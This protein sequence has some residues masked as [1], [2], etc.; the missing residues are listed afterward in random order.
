MRTARR[1]L[2]RAPKPMDAASP[3][4][5]LSEAGRDISH[6]AGRRRAGAL[7][8]LKP[9][10]HAIERTD[11][12]PALTRF[13][14][15]APDVELVWLSDGVA[16][17][18]CRRIR[19]AALRKY[20]RQ[21][22]R[23]RDRR[24]RRAG[25]CAEC[26]RQCS[27]RADRESTTRECAD[28]EQAAWCARSISKV[29]P[30]GEARF[31][32]KRQ[33]ARNRSRRSTFRSR[34]ATISL[35]LK[36]PANAPPARCNCSTSAGAA[37]AVGVITGA[38]ADTAQPLLASTFYLQRAL[39]PFADVRLARARVARPNAIIRFLDQNLPMLILADVGNVAGPARERLA[40]WIEDGGVLV[41][42]AGPRL[43]AADDDLVPVRLRRGGRTL[44]GSLSLGKA[45]AARGVLARKPVRRNGGAGRRYGNSPGAGGAGL[46]ASPSAPGQRSPT[47]RRW[48]PAARRGKG[49]DR[50]VSCDC[51]H[52]L[53]GS[54]AVGLF[55]RD[56]QAPG[57][58]R[59][60]DR[61]RRTGQC[62]AR[63]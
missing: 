22:H 43:A 7:R 51:R 35:G 34:S 29:L 23:H 18:A 17:R 49:I 58:A 46:P 32:F 61:D 44:G 21:S 28:R 12:L 63:P 41:R 27:R 59:R 1:I 24:R 60:L 48:L 38:T 45:A 57:C 9:K 37:A 47:A 53:V 33:R 3:I 40:K 31:A 19:R 39:N 50:A 10:P 4:I 62:R 14:S 20:R 30:L 5:P 11:A 16:S 6:A 25:A 8:T 36:S 54:A 26:R 55:R 52:A 15:A 2:S 56:A 42:F 13:L